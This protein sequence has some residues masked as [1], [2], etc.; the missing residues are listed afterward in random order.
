MNHQ[1][2][3]MHQAIILAN[4]NYRKK[5]IAQILEV[6]E[7]T[8]WNYLNGRGP[9]P[10]ARKPKTSKLDSFKPFIDS[11]LKKDAHFNNEKIF[12]MIQAQGYQGKI[13]ILRD[14]TRKFRKELQ[15]KVVIRFETEPGYQAQMD[16]KEL[17]RK[18]WRHFKAFVMLLGYSRKPFIRFVSDMKTPTFRACQN[19]AFEYFG[20]VPKTIL[21]DNM[22]TAWV[23]SAGEWN[24]NTKLLEQASHYGF[25]PHRCQVRSPETKGKVERL[26][27]YLS[28]NFLLEAEL[29]GRDTLE[30]LNK[31]IIPWLE[32][33][34]HKELTDFHETREERFSREKNHFD[35]A[36][37]GS[38][39][40][41]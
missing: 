1:E 39:R 24:V 31:R 37:E 13:S 6:S 18:N 11:I 33:V 26:I 16:W 4:Q 36:T 27:R 7:R 17:P 28:E 40:L 25:E 9:N 15:Q 2:K 3:R 23:N 34:G 35:T 21:Y 38:L 12:E 41:S 19:K 8:I 10:G 29:R 14:Y 32:M 30:E 20:G 5:D 22:K